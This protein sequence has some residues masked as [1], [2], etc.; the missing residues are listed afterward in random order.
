MSLVRVKNEW[1]LLDQARKVVVISIF[2]YNCAGVDGMENGKQKSFFLSEIDSSLLLMD[3]HGASVHGF[4]FSTRKRLLP[5][6]SKQNFEAYRSSTICVI[7]NSSAKEIQGTAPRVR[8]RV[9]F[10]I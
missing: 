1:S 6:E 4:A 7:L 3:V 10:G 8:E 2:N 9:L 5:H